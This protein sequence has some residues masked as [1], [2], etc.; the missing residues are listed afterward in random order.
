MKRTHSKSLLNE[1]SSPPNSTSL[2]EPSPSVSA[3]LPGNS[4]APQ[5][6]DVFITKVVYPSGYALHYP[7][8][9]FHFIPREIRDQLDLYMIHDRCHC[10]YRRDPMEEDHWYPD[11]C[12]RHDE[13]YIKRVGVYLW[14]N[15]YDD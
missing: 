4:N 14:L 5:T 2:N 12:L 7:L 3:T 9:Y 10:G 15:M 8:T 1:P 6:P 13:L 11:C